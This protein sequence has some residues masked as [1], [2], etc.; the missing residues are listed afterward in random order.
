[1]PVVFQN[2][3]TPDELIQMQLPGKFYKREEAKGNESWQYADMNNGSYYMLTRVRTH[4]T[5]FGHNEKIVFNKVD[6]MLYENIPGKILKKTIINKNGY[7]GFD[8][9]NRTRRGDLQRY[10]ILVTPYEVLVFKMSGNDGYIEGKEADVFFSS[11]KVKPTSDNKWKSY[12]PKQGGFAVMFPGMVGEGF[13]KSTADGT[14]R[15]EYEAVNNSTG[16]AYMI[17]KKSIYNFNFLEDDA[18]DL[19]LI[20]ESFKRSELVNKQLARKQG[21]ENNIPFFKL[22]IL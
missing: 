17:W 8:I 2:E 9:T 4:S 5:M 16:D 11:I 19:S 22:I 20:E 14:A 15:W 3:T 21:R 10:Q 7:Q 13:D 6:S 18:F 1:V 12:S